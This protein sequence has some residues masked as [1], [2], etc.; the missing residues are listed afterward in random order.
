LTKK[1]NGKF[2]KFIEHAIKTLQDSGSVNDAAEKLGV[3]G[4]QLRR[5]FS[6]YALFAPSYY[7]IDREFD[8]IL[9]EEQK[10][11]ILSYYT[12]YGNSTKTIHKISLNLGV[13]QEVIKKFIKENELTHDSLP[14]TKEGKKGLTFD[15]YL[16]LVDEMRDLNLNQKLENYQKE[17]L[18]VD[19]L[20]WR[21]FKKHVLDD[22][23]LAMKKYMPQYD[24]EKLELKPSKTKY[25]AVLSLQDYHFNRLAS[26]YD[27]NDD[28]SPEEQEIELFNGLTDLCS[29]IE[30]FGEAEKIFVTIGGDFV[31][32]D[33][34]KMTTT[35]GTAQDSFPSHTDSVVK[36]GLL[37]IKIIDFL[38]QYFKVIEFIPQK[39]N[40]DND[41]TVSLYMFL[42]AWYKDNAD[43][44]TNWDKKNIR[45][46]Q[47]RVYGTT[48]LAFMHGDGGRAKDWPIIIANE[49]REMWGRTKHTVL[50]TGHH[51]LRISQDLQGVQHN[52]VPSMASQDRWSYL[53]GYQSEK[54]FT[55]ILIDSENG[56]LAEI[57]SN[58]SKND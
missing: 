43:I 34:S 41:T 38:R 12:G 17:N 28:T 54:G 53:N 50:I 5:E 35:K 7:L 1:R 30:G 57:M 13:P 25:A 45:S 32:S 10:K 31:N 21:K 24:V 36:A 58:H 8:I 44:I 20:K 19:A 14:V 51:H 22:V 2:N 23:M 3:S 46:R 6:K 55:I 11:L 39:G 40:H 56:Y 47:Y 27:V 4:R 16:D 49:A 29:K 18:K 15:K 33:N 37:Y 52:Q 26:I 9:T 42:S 48:L